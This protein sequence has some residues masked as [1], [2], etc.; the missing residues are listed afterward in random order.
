[1]RAAR[2]GPV[3]I[4]DGGRPSH[5]LL[6]YEAYLQLSREATDIA[7]LL[8]MPNAAY[9]PFTAPRLGRVTQPVYLD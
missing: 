9:I 2:K 7:A 6:T 3:I 4:T 8:A 5:V 1:M